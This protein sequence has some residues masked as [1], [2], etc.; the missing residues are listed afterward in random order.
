MNKIQLALKDQILDTVKNIKKHNI[1]EILGNQLP[2]WYY[3]LGHG[4]ESKPYP[5]VQALEHTQIS[6]LGYLYT[7]VSTQPDS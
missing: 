2:S 4:P 6:P 1:G 3:H 5:P 7:H